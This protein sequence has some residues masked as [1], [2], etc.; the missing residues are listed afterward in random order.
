MAN[1][2]GAQV[3]SRRLQ[4]QGATRRSRRVAE[5]KSSLTAD[6]NLAEGVAHKVHRLWDRVKHPTCGLVDNASPNLLLRLSPDQ[7]DFEQPRAPTKKVQEGYKSGDQIE[8]GFGIVARS[9]DHL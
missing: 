9:Q 3:L 6:Q 7:T 5:V 8:N 2:T 4:A 1:P